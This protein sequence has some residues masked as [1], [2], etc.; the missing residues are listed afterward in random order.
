VTKGANF[1]G[2]QDFQEHSRPQALTAEL[3]SGGLLRGRQ[4]DR[5]GRQPRQGRPA[6]FEGLGGHLRHHVPASGLQA[7]ATRGEKAER[8][9]GAR[10]RHISSLIRGSDA[11]LLACGRERVDPAPLPPPPPLA[12]EIWCLNAAA[13]SFEAFLGVVPGN[14]FVRAPGHAAVPRCIRLRSRCAQRPCSSHATRSDPPR[15]LR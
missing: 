9:G 13:A 2:E 7:R 5:R 14:A 1:S 6:D 3:E 11:G 8:G 4:R 12:L 15:L 10:F